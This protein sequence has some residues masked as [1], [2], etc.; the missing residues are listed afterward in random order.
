MPGHNIVTLPIKP[1][2][3]VERW[4]CTGCGKCCRGNVVPL[5]DDD[6]KRFREQQWEKHPD[7]IGV[8]TIVRQGLLT[9]KYRLAQRADGRCV[10]L[11]DEGLCKIHQEFGFESKPLICRMY[12]LQLV[13]VSNTAYLTLRR[14]C[15]TAA[16]DL[17]REMKEHRDAARA[18]VKERPQLAESVRPPAIRHGHRRDWKD[19]L[20]VAGGIERLLTDQRFPLVR[21]LVHGLQ[22]C[23][24]LEQ[25]RLK[26]LDTQKLSEL[27]SVLIESAPQEA[28]ER[29]RGRVQPG[30]S[31]SV[32]FRQITA[33]YLRLH[34]GYVLRQTRGERFRM[35]A[36]AIAFARGT[37][38]IPKLH[39]SY[40][41]TT[42]EQIEA[43]QLGHMQES[44]Q[45]PFVRYFETTAVSKQYAMA[46]RSQW[47][48]IEKYRAVVAAYPVALWMLRYFCGDR[49]PQVEDVIDMVTTMDRGQ[50]YDPLGGRQHRR[51][52]AQLV[53]LNELDR[54]LIWYAR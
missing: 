22:F 4:D 18:F 46:G 42:F 34:P 50:G 27:V 37:G 9:R 19:T 23:E 51:R 3:I 1:L 48:L 8:K 10:F 36:A 52:I 17:G 47:S 12:P 41:E 45:E 13:P 25:C 24:L 6:L 16:A 43:I 26:K 53:Q 54:L 20:L 15:P 35:A 30:R 29:F 14:S 2:P 40:P 7:Y 5:D 28:A 33:D 31:A 32:L 49:S 39:E 38:S 44:L 21:R 11:T